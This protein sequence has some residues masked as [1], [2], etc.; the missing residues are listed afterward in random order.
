MAEQQAP[1]SLKGRVALVTGGSRGIGKAIALELARNGATVAFS[2]NSNLA[3]AEET[4]ADDSRHGRRVPDGAG[5]RRQQGEDAHRVV[6]TDPGE[7]QEARHPGQQ[8]RHY[9]RSHHEED[10]R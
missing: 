6:K 2:Y 8:R 3:T 1:D 7:I 9:P 10:D 5:R 4:A